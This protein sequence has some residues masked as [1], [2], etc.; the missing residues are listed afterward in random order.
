MRGRC[1][2]LREGMGMVGIRRVG[3]GALLLVIVVMI[4]VVIQDRM[5]KRLPAESPTVHPGTG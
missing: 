2:E 1:L 3:G 5:W 4:I